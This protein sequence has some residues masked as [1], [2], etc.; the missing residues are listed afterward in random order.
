MGVKRSGAG[1]YVYRWA[2]FPTLP[3]VVLRGLRQLVT[4]G[5]EQSLDAPPPAAAGP[6]WH[7]SDGEV[8]WTVR[9]RRKP[10]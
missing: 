5:V 8:S 3:P 4:I 2:T 6:S 10:S 1:V 7:F 9:R